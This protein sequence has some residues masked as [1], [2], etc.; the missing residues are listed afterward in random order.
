MRAG[1]PQVLVMGYTT[2]RMHREAVASKGVDIVI[3]DEVMPYTIY[4]NPV[5][6]LF[7]TLCRIPYIV[8][9]VLRMSCE[10]HISRK[11]VLW[12]NLTL[13]LSPSYERKDGAASGLI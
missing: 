3:C 12:T 1:K 6:K 4:R 5:V 11:G 13:S 7:S 9:R 2:F 10:G 8:Q